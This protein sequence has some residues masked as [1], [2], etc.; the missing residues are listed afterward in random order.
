MTTL[1]TALNAN[2][3]VF[4][5][6][7]TP[8]AGN[9]NSYDSHAGALSVTLPA[10]SGL[11]VGS[12]MLLEKYQGD[13]G[14]NAVTF[15]RAGSDTFDDAT[16][17]AVLTNP[18]EQ[19]LLEVI[20]P[21]STKQWKIIS[22]SNYKTGLASRVTE[23]NLNTSIVATDVITCT[24][25][26]ASLAAGSTFRIRLLGSVQV[27]ATSGLLTLTPF[28][29]NA[30]LTSSAIQMPSQTSA[31]G[32][33]GF[34]LEMYVTVRTAGAS[35]TAIAHGLGYIKFATNT[36]V[37]LSTVNTTATTV[38]TTASATE[39]LKIQAQWATSSATNILKVEV[40]TIERVI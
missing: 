21:V 35:G 3:A 11:T 13:T 10:L 17:T 12:T 33:V 16:T 15:T 22:R 20:Q 5:A 29:Q 19:I 37:H 1:A 25:P 18:G 40:A 34:S 24:L 26:E 27:Q 9:V 14:T 2:S 36:D 6:G 7:T 4:T 8:T 23:L 30:A 31:E 28:L 39:T 32:P 38:N